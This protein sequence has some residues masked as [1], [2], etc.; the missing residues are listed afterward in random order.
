MN[1]VKMDFFISL[2]YKLRFWAQD[3]SVFYTMNP[4]D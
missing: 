3:F 1:Q 2:Y 4:S